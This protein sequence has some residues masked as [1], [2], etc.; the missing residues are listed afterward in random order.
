MRHLFVAVAVW[1][2]LSTHAAAQIEAEE[3]V[4]VVI[5]NS[6]A[7]WPGDGQGKSFD[8]FY[9]ARAAFI[10]SLGNYD[11]KD[12]VT[13]LSVSRPRVIWTGSASNIDRK[14]KNG[15]L[16][17]FAGTELNGCASF[18][19]VIKRVKYQQ[20]QHA[21]PIKEIVFFS[22]LAETGPGPGCKWDPQNP[23]PPTSFYEYLAKQIDGTGT[24]LRFWWVDD[25]RTLSPTLDFFMERSIPV[26]VKGVEETIQ[27]LGG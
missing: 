5:D 19:E 2:L 7:V 1:L 23:Y 13:V 18:E 12:L 21:L 15:T 22:S 10:E 27:A 8:Q 25:E 11:R 3:H 20:I 26:E 16:R 4:I 17:K 14:S 24:K 9:R 6:G